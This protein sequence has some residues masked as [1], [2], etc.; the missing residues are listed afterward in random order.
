[1]PTENVEFRSN[2]ATCRG[3]FQ[4]PENAEPP[5]PTVVLGGGWCY[6][7]EVVLPHYADRFA[8][9]GLACLAFDYRNLGE[10][11][12]VDQEQHLD[13]QKQLEDYMS[14]ISYVES[15]EDVSEHQI[16]VF[17]ISYSG[18]HGLI[19][20][21][22]EPRAK[23]VASVVPVI[24]GWENMQRAHGEDHF[25]Q[26]LD[27]LQEDRRRRTDGESGTI[28]HSREPGVDWDEGPVANGAWPWTDVYETFE[29]IKANQAP[30]Y[31]HWSTLHSVDLLLDYDVM[32]FVRRN[33]DTPTKIIAT[34]ND[35]KCLWDLQVDAYNELKTDKKELTVVP[36]ASHMTIYSDEGLLE[37]A[38]DEGAK[39]YREHLI[40]AYE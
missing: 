35:E 39:W 38:A 37:I 9:E 16:G 27:A 34:Q 22:T 21:A 2:G 13:P 24:E 1:M 29:D 19:L 26:L 25:Y 6:V 20:S 10:S 23:C 12:I 14:A 7:K 33:N 5:Y 3:F 31:R 28:P 30:N 36:D 15:R 4:T 32:P 40:E 17:G 11:E 8:E 18:G